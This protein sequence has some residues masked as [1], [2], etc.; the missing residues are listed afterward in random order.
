M[1][2][3]SLVASTTGADRLRHTHQI[4]E[5]LAG[6]LSAG[7]HLPII[8]MTAH[9][10]KG[11]EARCLAAG[12]DAYLS[13]PIQPGKLFEIVERYLGVSRPP[14]SRTRLSLCTG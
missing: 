5:S 7:V 12:M 8:A 11:D 14:A 6:L 2:Y 4:I 3:R 13:K 1:C 9:A 10:M